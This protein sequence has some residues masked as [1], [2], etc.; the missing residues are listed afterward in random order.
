MP[1]LDGFQLAQLIKD[2]PG[3]TGTMI[4]MLSSSDVAD[5]IKRCKEIGI[6]RYLRKPV[7]PSELFDAIMSVM[8]RADKVCHGVASAQYGLSKP[9]RVL[10]VLV[11]EDHPINQMV[12]EEILRDRGHTFS[13]ANNGVQVLQML[14][15]H[16]F[17]VI[18]MDG[19]MPQM[20]GYQTTREIRK[21]EKKTG[22]H[23]RIIA[24]TA[25]AM[26]ED[27]ARCLAVGMDDYVS[28]PIDPSSLL[29]QLESEQK[30]DIGGEGTDEAD[31]M[32]TAV[33]AFDQAS[34]LKRV[35]GKQARLN[36]LV[37]VF[38]QEMSSTMAGIR[39]AVATGNL[40]QVASFSHRLKGA[41]STISAKP[42]AD[43]ASELEQIAKT[44]RHQ[45]M[46]AALDALQTLATALSTDLEAF[47]AGDGK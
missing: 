7:K 20:D 29:H 31:E 12:V 10:N 46:N 5:E 16:L 23:I 14:D 1:G 3:L 38:L 34:A 28:K 45:S 15:Q 8:G 2:T 42:V 11:A 36:Q 32:A 30:S 26:K 44:G 33:P 6:A 9:V 21:R 17:D 40:E 27:R 13:T 25:A 18:L 24:L 37:R 22:K 35:N 47:I 43:A 39:E 41:A 19:Q 4:M